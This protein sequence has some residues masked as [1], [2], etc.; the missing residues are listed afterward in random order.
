MPE[1][2]QEENLISK[3]LG[4]SVPIILRPVG[5]YYTLIDEA[6]IHGIMEGEAMGVDKGNFELQ[7]FIMI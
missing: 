6:H 2:A 4:C 1:R 7:D 5:N 3:F